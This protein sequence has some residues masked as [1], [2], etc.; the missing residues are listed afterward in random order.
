MKKLFILI[1]IASASHFTYGQSCTPSCEKKS[2]GPEGTKREEAAVISSMRTDVQTV[3]EKMAK[4]PIS[5]DRQIAAMKIEKG[6][7]DD[8]S[9]LFLSQA[10]TAIRYELLNKIESSKLIAAL[11][12]YKPSS[13]STKQQMVMSLR[14]EIQMIASQ[15]EKL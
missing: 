13:Y 10:V 8:E 6:Q 15:A 14:K 11:R 9:L 7:S 1:V 2:C 3:L 4:S 12:E 5:F